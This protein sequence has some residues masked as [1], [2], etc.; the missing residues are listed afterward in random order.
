MYN[1]ICVTGSADSIVN[2]EVWAALLDSNSN[3]SSSIEL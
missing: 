3:F 1:L 2:K